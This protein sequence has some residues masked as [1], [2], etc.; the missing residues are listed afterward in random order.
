MR[1]NLVLLAAVFA[2]GSQPVLTKAAEPLLNL[3][4]GYHEWSRQLNIAIGGALVGI[5]PIE[6]LRIHTHV[7]L[8]LNDTLDETD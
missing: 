6:P 7:V 3:S 2:L 1:T 4:E 5:Y 8:K